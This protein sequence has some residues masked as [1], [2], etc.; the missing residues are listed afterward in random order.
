MCFCFVSLQVNFEDTCKGFL[1]V[2]KVWK[3]VKSF[4][5]MFLGCVVFVKELFSEILMHLIDIDLQLQQAFI[6]HG[7]F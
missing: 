1:E 4:I 7:I 5:R 2:A 6:L 3:R